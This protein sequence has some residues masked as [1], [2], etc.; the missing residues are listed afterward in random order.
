MFELQ[1]VFECVISFICAL[2]RYFTAF[3]LFKG[4][5]YFQYV[6]IICWTMRLILALFSFYNF[7][8]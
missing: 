5:K 1:P 2:V 8:F 3:S 4:D 6:P 7:C